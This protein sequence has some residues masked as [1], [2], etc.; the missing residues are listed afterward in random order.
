MKLVISMHSSKQK[1]LAVQ[2]CGIFFTTE[3]RI[4]EQL[5]CWLK[6]QK[7]LSKDLKTRYQLI[8]RATERF[9]CCFKTNALEAVQVRNRKERN[10]RK[11]ESSAKIAHFWLI[12]T[13]IWNEI[14]YF[15]NKTSFMSNF[16]YKSQ[17]TSLS[18]RSLSQLNCL[19]I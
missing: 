17:V 19:I 2:Y 9:L 3:E 11:K 10:Q 14:T 7:T 1:A 12:V 6:I 4:W 15:L 5:N 18:H 8:K 13:N 16:R